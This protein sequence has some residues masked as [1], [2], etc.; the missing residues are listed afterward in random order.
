MFNYKIIEASP[1]RRNVFLVKKKMRGD[2]V[3]G[4]KSYDKILVPIAKN[5]KIHRRQFPQILV[6]IKLKYCAHA[7]KLFKSII[8]DIY[9][10]ETKTISNSLAAQFH[11]SQTD[12]MKQEIIKELSQ[13]NSKIRVVFPTSALSTEVNMP[14]IT[15]VIHIAPPASPEEYVQEVVELGDLGCNHMHIC[16]IVTQIYQIIDQKRTKLHNQ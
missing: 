12:S 1:N 9:E 15:T 16:T 10:G 5:L 6:Y 3:Y 14:H 11:A 4:V 7:Y 2:S 8:E 13:Q